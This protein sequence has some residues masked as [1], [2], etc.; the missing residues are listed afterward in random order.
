MQ[1]AFLTEAVKYNVLPLDDRVYER[2][3]PTVA[4]RPNLMGGRTSL[5]VY[6]GMVG[7]KENAFINTKDSSYTITAE[8]EL[9]QS[10]ASGVLLAQGSSHAGWSLYVK[11]GNPKFAYNYLGNVTTIS[12]A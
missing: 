7:M 1:A 2:F 9:P 8:V 12:S 6:E 10:A 3:N 11:D 4:G 5:T